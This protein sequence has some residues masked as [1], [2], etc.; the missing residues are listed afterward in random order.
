MQKHIMSSFLQLRATT[1]YEIMLAEI[2]L[3]SLELGAMRMLI[4]NIQRVD[5]IYNQ[6]LPNKIRK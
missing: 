5:E 1:P 2:G 3:Y 6:Q 4:L